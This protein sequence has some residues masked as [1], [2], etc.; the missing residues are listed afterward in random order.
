MI[1]GQDIFK[2]ADESRPIAQ[3]ILKFSMPVI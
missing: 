3:K 2:T 1:I